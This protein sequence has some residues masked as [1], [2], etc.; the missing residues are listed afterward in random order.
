MDIQNL[1]TVWNDLKTA[2]Q[3]TDVLLTDWWLGLDDTT[4]LRELIKALSQHPEVAGAVMIGRSL[5]RLNLLLMKLDNAVV[6]ERDVATDRLF[7]SLARWQDEASGW[8]DLWDRAVQDAL[9]AD[10]RTE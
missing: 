2:I 9:S 3:N 8:I 1:Q 10:A 6:A 5:A 4:V 7:E